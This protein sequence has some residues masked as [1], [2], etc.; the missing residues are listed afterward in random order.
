[1]TWHFPSCRR[2]LCGEDGVPVEADAGFFCGG[3][4][5]RSSSLYPI[6]LLRRLLVELAEVVEIVDVVAVALGG[7]VSM[8]SSALRRFMG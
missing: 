4:E 3:G 2:R 7:G 6:L 5:A 8:V 1:M